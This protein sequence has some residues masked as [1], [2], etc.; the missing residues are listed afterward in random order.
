MHVHFE[1]P[2]CERVCAAAGGEVGGKFPRTI[3]HSTH[4]K[5]C[6]ARV[7]VRKFHAQIML[8][9]SAHY[10]YKDVRHRPRQERA[11]FAG[12]FGV[13][14]VAYIIFRPDG[15]RN[16][17]GEDVFFSLL[18]KRKQ[19]SSTTT[20]RPEGGCKKNERRQSYEFPGIA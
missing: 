14:G 19:K 12:C 11:T 10:L 17:T 1:A 13:V 6:R 3:L 7:Y 20:H 15:A 5:V 9:Q 8:W 2:M 16:A 4:R 18:L